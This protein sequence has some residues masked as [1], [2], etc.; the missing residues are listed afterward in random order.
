MTIMFNI[1]Q[2]INMMIFSNKTQTAKFLICHETNQVS[3]RSGDMLQTNRIGGASC[4]K[5]GNF[6]RTLLDISFSC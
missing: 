5:T 2:W 3:K 4:F 1:Q 6:R